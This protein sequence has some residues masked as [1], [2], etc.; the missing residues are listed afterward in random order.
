M[1]AYLLLSL[2]ITGGC[3]AMQDKVATKLQYPDR[4]ISI[5]VFGTATGSVNK[6]RGA[7]ASG[8]NELS[9]ASPDGYM[10][11]ITGM[12]MLLLSSYGPTKY[13]YSTALDPLMQIASVPMVMA[14]QSDQP[15]QTASEKER[16]IIKP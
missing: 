16:G 1:T 4:P 13:N 9:G 7:G 10:I 2:L 6:S 11:G 8:W 5:I 15:W 14:V 12:D 3:T